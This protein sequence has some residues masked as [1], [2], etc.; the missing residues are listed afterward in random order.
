MTMPPQMD[1]KAMESLK[2][3][4]K[5]MGDSLSS[6]VT[7]NI[8]LTM[9][10]GFGAEKLFGLIRA[11]TYFVTIALI[12]VPY[13]SGLMFFYSQLVY[14]L[15]M[16]LLQGPFWYEKFFKFSE[17][18]PFSEHFVQFEVPDMNFFMNAGSVPLL[19]LLIVV[20][21]IVFKILL[22]LSKLFY[23]HRLWRI[24]GMKSEENAQLIVPIATVFT[25]GYI[26]LLMAAAL[27]TMAIY[28]CVDRS[29]M[30]YWFQNGSDLTNSVVTLT[31]M[32]L[33]ISIPIAIGAIVY[34]NG[35]RLETNSAIKERYGFMYEPYD[36]RR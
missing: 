2:G 32:A 20:Q 19:L 9:L 5:S 33:L 34:R 29:T 25:E 24:I 18:S 11:L 15:G 36:M 27:N 22:M 35:K 26:E 1:A 7:A 31:C 23:R 4:T 30:S 8:F 6:A 13:S 3:Q 12:E 10:F 28:A 21:A 17:T 16:D 14:L